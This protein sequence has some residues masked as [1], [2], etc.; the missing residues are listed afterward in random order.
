VIDP[1]PSVLR[2]RSSWLLAGFVVVVL[3]LAT[4]VFLQTRSIRSHDDLVSKRAAAVNAASGEVV[5]LLTVG[6]TNAAVDLKKLLAGATAG[7][8]DQLEQQ[9]SSFQKALAQGQVTSTGSVAAAALVSMSGKSA[10]VDIAAKATVKNTASPSGDPRNYRL[11][12][13]VEQVNGHW[14]VSGLS[15]VV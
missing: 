11:T 10:T 5:A 4:L 6:H 9:A 1:P 2:R 15:F 7:F 3:V 13:T 8:H 14:L 12:V